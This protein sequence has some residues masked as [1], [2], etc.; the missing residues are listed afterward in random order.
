MPVAPIDSVFESIRVSDNDWLI[1][2]SIEQAGTIYDSLG[3]MLSESPQGTFLLL[4]VGGDHFLQKIWFKNFDKPFETKVVFGK[5]LR[6]DKNIS[7]D[8][9]AD[10]I[11]LA[12][13]EWIY[14][15]VYKSDTDSAYNVLEPSD[16]EPYYSM[17]FKTLKTDGSN[18]F[19]TE[20]SL[21]KS[22]DVQ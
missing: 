18:L 7:F 4:K 19:F 21:S 22:K 20:T 5:R 11:L 17:C 13:K 3:N 15:F 1:S 6:L 2:L 16:H 9:S 12:N 10:S 8:Y 14:P